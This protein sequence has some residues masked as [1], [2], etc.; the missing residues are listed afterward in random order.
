MTFCHA[1]RIVELIIAVLR[2][3]SFSFSVFYVLVLIASINHYLSALKSQCSFDDSCYDSILLFERSFMSFEIYREDDRYQ[4]FGLSLFFFVLQN[5]HQI[6]KKRTKFNDDNCFFWR[7]AD[8]LVVVDSP[9]IVFFFAHKLWL[10]QLTKIHAFAQIT[11]T[12][13]TKLSKNGAL[14]MSSNDI[15]TA[16]NDRILFLS[17]NSLFGCPFR[18]QLIIFRF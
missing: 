11:S 8:R 7:L 15:V 9:L 13:F 18:F 4:W 16:S 3:F 5:H 12:K 14:R 10:C 17:I 1:N 6:G 2:F